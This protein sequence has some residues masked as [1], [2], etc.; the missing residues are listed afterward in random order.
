MA[1][2][3]MKL[4]A[5]LRAANVPEQEAREAA[6]EVATFESRLANVEARLMVLTWMVGFNLVMTV[7]IVGKLFLGK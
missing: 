3:L 1:I 4:H 6:E 2:G 5:A 7:A